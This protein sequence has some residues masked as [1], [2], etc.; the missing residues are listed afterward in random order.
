MTP[1]QTLSLAQT[2][3]VQDVP[4]KRALFGN[5][6]FLTMFF[7]DNYGEETT[8]VYY[9]GFRGEWLRLNREP[10]EVLYERAANPRD[11]K[12]IVGTGGLVE[13]EEL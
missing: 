9:V 4:V 3:D 12:A 5:T 8:G 1:V 2:A 10:V 11:H 6:Y 13:Y 7:E